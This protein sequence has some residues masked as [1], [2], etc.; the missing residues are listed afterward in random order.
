MKTFMYCSNV[1]FAFIFSCTLTG[2]VSHYANTGTITKKS[3]F[4]RVIERAKKDKWYFMLHSGINIYKINYI[5]V[6]KAKR[7]MTVQ[8]D[9]VDSLHLF[10]VKNPET[11]PYKPTPE[12]SEIH[13]YMKDSTSYT[14]DEPQDLLL[15]NVAKIE[16]I[17]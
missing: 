10:Y 9:K 4:P 1:V 2:C 12:L 6:D 14:L 8:L 11:K 13:L 3:S 16:L 5:E 15:D 7:Q 17:N